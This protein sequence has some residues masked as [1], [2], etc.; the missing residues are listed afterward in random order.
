MDNTIDYN[1]L[2]WDDEYRHQH[3]LRRQAELDQKS[4]L[5]PAKWIDTFREG[6]YRR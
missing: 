4:Q 6:S 3:S 2:R 1:R 5:V